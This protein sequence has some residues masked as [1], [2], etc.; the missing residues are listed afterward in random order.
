MRLPHGETIT[1][2]RPAGTSPR[3][4]PLPTVDHTVGGCAFAPR[5]S[6][7]LLDRRDT[8][9][10]GLSLYAPPGADIR[11]TDRIVRADGTVW[12][13]TGEPG[14]W[15]T[16]WSGWHPGIEVALTRVTG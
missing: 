7:E 16:P 12:E 2:R 3:G 8:V 14:D 11:P 6:T 1:V 4:D 5:T 10:I 15:L 9:T 13:V